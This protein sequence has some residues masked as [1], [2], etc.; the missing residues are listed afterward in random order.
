M[1]LRYRGHRDLAEAFLDAYANRVDDHDLFEVVDF[2]A[3][4]RAL[5]RAKVAALAASQS[6]IAAPQRA[7][8]RQSVE[9]HLGLAEA[10]L[11]PPAKA[12]L[13]LMCGTVGSG[14]SSV[15]R[16]L[17]RT[18]HGISIV[19]DRV[20]KNRAG[21]APDEHRKAAPDEGL[22]EPDQVELV[23]REMLERAAPILAS[24]RNAILD[25]SFSRRR[26]RELA[27]DWARERGVPARLVEVRCDP[28]VALI[29]LREREQIGADPSDAGPDFLPISR[30]RF[31]SPDEWSEGDRIVIHSDDEGWPGQLASR[32]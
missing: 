22:Y 15:A 5:V 10:L 30:E 3:A 17:A 7:R 14:K 19:S 1:D 6:S 24:G 31:E 20:R 25:A 8:A 16:Q 12:G 21:L 9:R 28:S 32:I 13:L 26:W 2:F 11:D 4:Y 18:G 23:Y 27:R 29:R